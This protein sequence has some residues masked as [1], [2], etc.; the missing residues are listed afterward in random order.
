MTE[1]DHFKHLNENQTYLTPEDWPK[2]DALLD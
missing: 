1:Q 2:V